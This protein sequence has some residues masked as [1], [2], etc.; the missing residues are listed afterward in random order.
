MKTSHHCWWAG[1]RAFALVVAGLATALEHGSLGQAACMSA[2]ALDLQAATVL[3][4]LQT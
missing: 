4:G 2:L 3:W 1:Q